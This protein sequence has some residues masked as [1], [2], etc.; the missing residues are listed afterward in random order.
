MKLL[1]NIAVVGDRDSVLAFEAVGVEVYTPDTPEEI[2][3]II[4]SLADKEYGIIFVTEEKAQLVPETIDRYNSTMVPALILIPSSK[5][6]LGIGM[7]K[8][9][10]NVE[11]AIGSNIL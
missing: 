7:D 6:S 3:R 8:I 2:R 11:K 1:Y 9:N 4:D 5:G 10:K